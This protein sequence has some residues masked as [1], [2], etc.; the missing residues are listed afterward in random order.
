MPL[1]LIYPFLHVLGGG[2]EIYCK[3]MANKLCLDDYFFNWV[4]PKCLF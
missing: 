4:S 1:E 3:E 2:G